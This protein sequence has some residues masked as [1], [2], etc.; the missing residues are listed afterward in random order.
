[1]KNNSIGM[2]FAKL[3]PNIGN[4]KFSMFLLKGWLF[5]VVSIT[6]TSIGRL[7]PLLRILGAA[8]MPLRRSPS[9]GLFWFLLIKA[10]SW[11]SISMRWPDTNNIDFM[12]AHNPYIYSWCRYT[13]MHLQ[14]QMLLKV[15]VYIM[16]IM[17]QCLKNMVA[18]H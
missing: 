9:L 6:G 18:F 5:M 13:A 10:S 11:V 1:M 2:G 14:F 8:W 16:V 15:W 17:V 12:V 3:P 4:C 7:W